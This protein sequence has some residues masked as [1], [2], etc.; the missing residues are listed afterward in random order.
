MV[1]VEQRMK[2]NRYTSWL[3]LVLMFSGLAV[4]IYWP[5]RSGGWIFD[6]EP[7]IANY[8]R[9]RDFSDSLSFLLSGRGISFLSFALNIKL[10]GLDP[11]VFRWVNVV[12][13]TMNSLLV[14]LLL[15]QLTGS[16]WRWAIVGGLF[17]LCHPLQT[18][19]V[20]YVVQRM[21]IL[22][23]FFA[24]LAI[25]LADRYLILVGEGRGEESRKFL[26]MSVFCGIFSVMSKENT[27]LLPLV[28]PLLAWFRGKGRLAAG[29]RPAFTLW[30]SI[31]VV[32]I[33][34]QYL[35]D[36]SM[37][38]RLASL[39]LY[40]DT[41]KTLYEMLGDQDRAVMPIR[42]FL[43]QLEV[44]WVY[45]GL[46][47]F[48]LRQALDYCRPI[49][50]LRLSLLHVGTLTLVATALWFVYKRRDRAPFLFLGIAW[51]L[52]FTVVESSLIPLDPI[53]EHRLYLPL[54]GVI[55]IFRDVGML[56]PKKIGF[57]AA[58]VAICFLAF[59]SWERNS[60]W[61][62]DSVSFWQSNVNVVPRAPRPTYKLAA[63]LFEQKRFAEA[64][65]KVK[66]LR[67]QGYIR[68]MTLGE[69]LYFSGKTEEAMAVFRRAEQRGEPGAN[70]TDFFTGYRAIQEKRYAEAKDW[71]DRA[72]RRKGEDVK[73]LYARGM[74]AEAQNDPMGAVKYYFSAIIASQ[75][76]AASG[77]MAMNSG[78]ALWAKERRD[79][80]LSQLSE[81]LDRERAK[82][83]SSPKNIMIREPFAYQLMQLGL[84]A[85]AFENYDAL[86]EFSPKNGSLYYKLGIVCERMGRFGDAEKN[87]KISHELS[88]DN[89]EAA[90]RFATILVMRGKLSA[91]NEVLLPLL[92]QHPEDG[93]FILLYAN[94]LLNKGE[95][96]A[97]RA[98]YLRASLLPGYREQALSSLKNLNNPRF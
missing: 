83:Q 11:S 34:Y 39:P 96:D 50:D 12:I 22:S 36:S 62:G 56:W 27:V 82:V 97:A 38:W 53:F 49:A 70:G 55:F 63:T 37:T 95:V 19:A 46:V 54:V 9:L 1:E 84:Y 45:L 21:T 51:I 17:F 91:A 5:A 52:I 14:V 35:V 13:H 73:I 41:G 47:F 67:A 72:E 71:L 77:T 94:L 16:A 43:S 61:G 75:S 3:L 26:L 69:V 20:S 76:W 28:I 30:L 59:L 89:A 57:F 60:V 42:Y 8:L 25:L 64:L 79:L 7:N 68:D 33:L 66:I 18:S 86:R 2:T 40:K 85:E 74:L 6:D 92:Q 4:A 31:S 58:V 29:W 65:D 78:Y 81:W 88:R 98:A 32:A 48:P 23:A 10:W 44:F 24:L 87:Y 90:L 93:R 80:L 15:R